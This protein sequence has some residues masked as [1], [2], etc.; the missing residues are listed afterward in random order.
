M[1]C[2][3]NIT[4]KFAQTPL[5]PG[6]AGTG[7]MYALETT[8][9]EWLAEH[10]PD[11]DVKGTWT[12]LTF[13]DR[14][15]L[16]ARDQKLIPHVFENVTYDKDGFEKLWT[17]FSKK[18][19]FS[20]EI[21]DE[22]VYCVTHITH[23]LTQSTPLAPWLPGSFIPLTQQKNILTQIVIMLSQA[24]GLKDV[25]AEIEG[26]YFEAD[27]R[28]HG[29]VL[30]SRNADLQKAFA[31]F[32]ETT[33]LPPH[34]FVK[35]ALTGGQN[36]PEMINAPIVSLRFSQDVTSHSVLKARRL[37]QNTNFPIESLSHV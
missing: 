9:P 4:E 6:F 3:H 32:L 30:T 24:L 27:G 14:T 10:S 16:L 13:K 36:Q 21:T 34:M 20:Q 23:L 8:W 5:K 19:V 7:L 33:P 37:L 31:T 26:Q 11:L 28:R 12:I 15:Q 2:T 25:T 22:D 17:L 35:Q 18:P 29:G 1:L